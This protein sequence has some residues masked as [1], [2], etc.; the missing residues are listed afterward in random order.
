MTWKKVMPFAVTVALSRV[1]TSWLGTSSTVSIMFIL[2][3]TRSMNGHDQ[4]E[5]RLQRVGVTT[6]ALDRVIVPLRDSLHRGE[7][8]EDDEAR[9]AL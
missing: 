2:A 8:D 5:A 1:M 7:H 3:P 9:E 4:V 6:E